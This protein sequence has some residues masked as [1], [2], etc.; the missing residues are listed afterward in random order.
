MRAA[1]MSFDQK[2]KRTKAAAGQE[3]DVEGEEVDDIRG[4]LVS[5]A[6]TGPAQEEEKESGSG[7]SWTAIIIFLVACALGGIGGAMLPHFIGG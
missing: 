7:M 2:P 4:E 6:Y 3:S 1:K 5:Q